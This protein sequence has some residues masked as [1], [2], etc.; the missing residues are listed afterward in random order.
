MGK[1]GLY[2]IPETIDLNFSSFLPNLITIHGVS[3]I[4]QSIPTAQYG[5]VVRVPAS[6]SKCPEAVCP[7]CELSAPL[8]KYWQITLK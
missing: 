3:A 6:Y 5:V 4:P 2:Y 1:V 7:D 8:G